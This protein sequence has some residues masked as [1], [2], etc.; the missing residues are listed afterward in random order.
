MKNENIYLNIMNTCN[1]LSGIATFII[2]DK[3][4]KDQSIQQGDLVF[5]IIKL[6]GISIIF[7][8]TPGTIF[9]NSNVEYII[10]TILYYQYFYFLKSLKTTTICVPYRGF[11]QQDKVP[12]R[13]A[14]Q[15]DK[16]SYRGV[17]QQGKTVLTEKVYSA[18]IS[19]LFKLTDKLSLMVSELSCKNIILQF[20]ILVIVHQILRSFV[21]NFIQKIFEL[22]IFFTFYNLSKYLNQNVY[23]KLYEYHIFK[24]TTDNFQL[25]SDY[26]FNLIRS[27]NEYKR[28]KQSNLLKAIQKD[29][30]LYIDLRSDLKK[31][32]IRGLISYIISHILYI[33]DNISIN[34][35]F[36]VFYIYNL[37]CALTIHIHINNLISKV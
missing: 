24:K 36:W 22:H 20:L 18:L 9:F 28:Y 12:Y 31:Y 14:T 32:I 2:A 21:F 8:N 19:S 15:Q 1:I 3:F 23:S 27:Q 35:C 16:L 13:G 29:I 7:A 33:Y 17:T 4:T 6:L 11:T 25:I 26:R 5:N 30:K 37:N 34:Y 10:Y